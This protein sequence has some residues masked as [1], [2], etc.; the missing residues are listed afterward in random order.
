MTR[1]IL[2]AIILDTGLFDD[3]DRITKQIDLLKD[4]FSDALAPAKL[5]CYQAWSAYPQDIREGTDLILFDYGG[6]G[7]GTDL[8]QRN[9]NKLIEWA[10]DHPNS[11]VVVVSDMTYDW[12]VKPEFEELGLTEIH[13]IVCGC[14]GETIPNWF[15]EV[16]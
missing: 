8:P 5:D 16:K 1:T 4:T 11:L 12:Y 7:P 14:L 15:K 9:A 3:E 10:H 13:N 2:T 6:M